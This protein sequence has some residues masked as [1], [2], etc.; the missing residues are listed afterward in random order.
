[1]SQALWDCDRIFNG[2]AFA[3][4][5]WKARPLIRGWETDSAALFRILSRPNKEARPIEAA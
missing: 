2:D 1:M 5:L 4:S 3:D